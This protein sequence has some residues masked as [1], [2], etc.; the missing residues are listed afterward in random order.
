MFHIF[1]FLQ[2]NM[3]LGI[4]NPLSWIFHAVSNEKRC[5]ISMP[6]LS[7][8]NWREDRKFFPAC[9]I[10]LFVNFN[11]FTEVAVS[12]S[13]LAW[14]TPNLGILWISVCSFWL[15]GSIV[16][17]PIIYRL[18]PSPSRFEIRQWSK[19][20]Q[21]AAETSSFSITSQTARL[22]ED[23]LRQSAHK[24]WSTQLWQWSE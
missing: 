4:V 10:H 1:H 16:A 18:V 19:C 22:P 21:T 2:C 9:W 7:T 17:N 3:V 13:K 14:L 5:L 11:I 12:Q 23:I 6:F 20:W 15:C 24:L 8:Y